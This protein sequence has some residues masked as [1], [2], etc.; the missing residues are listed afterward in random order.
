MLSNL[1]GQERRRG[2]AGSAC[3]NCLPAD[4]ALAV[5][6]SQA[7]AP[8][9]VST[10]TVPAART[11]EPCASRHVE[12]SV[13][14]QSVVRDLGSGSN[15]NK[16][17]GCSCSRHRMIKAVVEARVDLLSRCFH[18]PFQS[19]KPSKPC[20]WVKIEHARR[21][22]TPEKSLPFLGLASIYREIQF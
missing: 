17:A 3:T 7:E 14:S 2:R 16:H 8:C 1:G 15:H 9:H 4:P 20:C 11:C 6:P 12:R 10:C 13:R 22:P 19:V 21:L 18:G 5:A